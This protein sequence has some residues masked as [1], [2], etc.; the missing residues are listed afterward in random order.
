M[1][2]VDEYRNS[3]GA[4][5]LADAIR[6]CVTRPWTLMEV[7]GGQTH[8][9]AKYNLQELLPEPITLLHGPGCPVCVTPINQIDMAVHIASQPDVI[10]CSF[11]D[12]L[13]V[14]GSNEDLLSVKSKGGDLRIVYSPMDALKIAKDN[15]NNEVVFFAIGFETTA[16]ANA[17]AIYKANIENIKNISFLVSQVLVPPA[18]TSILSSPKNRVQGLLAAGHVCA[19]MGYEE[20]GPIAK[21]Y[22]IPIV[23]TGFEPLDI[24]QGIFLCVKQL[25]EGRA[26]VENQ[27]SRVVRQAGN[28]S[29]QK[30]IQ[31]V[32]KVIPRQWRGIGEIP[33]SG[34][35]LRE[36]YS[37]FDAEKKFSCETH[38]KEQST[39]CIS[40]LIL[41]GIKKPNECPAFGKA[42]TPESP[43]GA[44]MVS[45]EGACAAYF[46]YQPVQ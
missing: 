41:Q 4:H 45:T 11:G 3:E 15:P 6:Q 32:F 38:S 1:K 7:C 26:E 40:G 30:I 10:F 9:I 36:T 39:E 12:M 5:K 34:L 14:P 44:T 22:N 23:V 27:Y 43:L 42:C 46:R 2:Y 37:K 29:A 25:E 24:L 18:V 35:G 13:R 16:P 19:I 8:S 21:N 28:L 33:N 20:Y 31:E 17:M